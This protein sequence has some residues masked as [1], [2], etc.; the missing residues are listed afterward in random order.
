MPIF[1][2]S[3][4]NAYR[5]LLHARIV[6]R[7]EVLRVLGGPLPCPRL[8]SVHVVHNLGCHQQ[9]VVDGPG[10]PTHH[11]TMLFYG[12]CLHYVSPTFGQQPPQANAMVDAITIRHH[13]PCQQAELSLI[14]HSIMYCAPYKH[15]IFFSPSQL[16]LVD[17][18]ARS[19]GMRF[20]Q[21]ATRRGDGTTQGRRPAIR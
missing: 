16:N 13:L 19:Q 17:F 18:I 12:P 5:R 14:L 21:R 8:P 15:K 20:I 3:G 1:Y 10:V 6:F 2:H 4:H 7:I 9:C 11:H